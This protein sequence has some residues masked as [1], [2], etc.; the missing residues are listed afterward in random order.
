MSPVRVLRLISVAA[1]YALLKSSHFAENLPPPPAFS[2]VSHSP[3]FLRAAVS[4]VAPL[5]FSNR[6]P[7]IGHSYRKY[8]NL[9]PFRLIT[10]TLISSLIRRAATNETARRPQVR[11]AIDGLNVIRHS[12]HQSSWKHSPARTGPKPREFPQF[13][14]SISVRAVCKKNLQ[15]SESRDTEGPLRSVVTAM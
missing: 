12:D 14:G 6:S 11:A 4:V 3:A 10:I 1:S 13:R 2:S 15:D 7:V 5:L 8:R 9:R